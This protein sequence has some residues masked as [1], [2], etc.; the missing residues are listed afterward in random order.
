MRTWPPCAGHTAPH[1]TA[2][3]AKPRRSM[4]RHGCGARHSV[5]RRAL[6]RLV[7]AVQLAQHKVRRLHFA[8]HHTLRHCTP[9]A[10]PSRHAVRAVPANCQL[11][12]PQAQLGS[13]ERM[14][15]RGCRLSV[16]CWAVPL[17][18]WGQEDC[19]SLEPAAEGVDR[20]DAHARENAITHECG[21]VR[22]EHTC[23]HQLVRDERY[24]HY[25]HATCILHRAT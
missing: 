22:T 2:E 16:R 23:G 1:G 11:C 15:A 14:D 4:A 12:K 5:R 10:T 13:R 25:L 7:R 24:A 17:A 3:Q 8:Y 6:G 21:G 18:S 9:A 19:G 20:V